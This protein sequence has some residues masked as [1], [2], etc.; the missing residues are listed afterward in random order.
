MCKICGSLTKNIF[1]NKVN[2]EFCD[3]CGFLC[4]TKDYI[5]SS[6][7]EYNRYL[8]HSNSENENYINYQKKFYDEINDFL[9]EKVLDY[10]CGDNHILANILK[11]NGHDSMY[12][13]LYF[14]PDIKYEKYLYD[15]I[16]LEEVIEHLN[17][18][19]SVITKLIKL[20]NINGKLIIRTNFIP[21]N[22]V[23]KNWWYLRDITHISFFDIKTFQYIGN[24]L[25]M[26]IIYCNEKDLIVFEKA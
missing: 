12:Y 23:E 17:D 21:K 6:E 16:I 1:I 8:L 3:Y 11:E 25:S 4:K 18:P 13:D 20:L 9:G 7:D 15:A 24:L 19:L 22:V 14:Y 10:G 2:Y 5:L 26:R